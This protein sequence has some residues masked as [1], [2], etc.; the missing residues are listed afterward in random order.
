MDAEEHDRLVNSVAER[1]TDYRQQEIA[2]VDAAHVRKWLQQFEDSDQ[3]I[4]LSEIERLL[5]KTYISRTVAKSWMGKLVLNPDLAGS[6]PKDFW[7]TSGFLR[8]Q[9]GSKS[10]TDML[11]L[12][13][14][15]LTEQFKLSTASQISTSNTYVYLDDVSFSGNQ[16]KNGLL[17]VPQTPS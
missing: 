14:E 16:I 13:D 9:T 17:P 1:V 11:T 7:S 10:Q 15:V 2:R 6:S 5:H 4:I 12:L 3:P 8:L